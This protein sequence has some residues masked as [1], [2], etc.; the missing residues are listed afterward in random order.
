MENKM[1]EALENQKAVPFCLLALVTLL[2]LG[3]LS[4]CCQEPV[5]SDIGT[6]SIHAAMLL[7]CTEDGT[8]S[9]ETV[10]S[11]SEGIGAD[12]YLTGGDE[13]IATANGQSQTLTEEKLLFN[14]VRYVTEFDFDDPGAEFTISLERPNYTPAPNSHVTLPERIAIQTPQPDESFTHEESITLAWE[15]S[16]T[17]DEVNVQFA[18]SCRSGD[19]SSAGTRYFTVADSGSASYT[20]EDLL[21]GQEL[22]ANASCDVTITLARQKSGSLSPEYRGG[23]IVSRRESS[24]SVEIVP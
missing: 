2:A 9:V 12:I 8:T 21:S 14:V 23:K 6:D 17:P 15:P 22:G 16:G 3:L 1:K 5:D 4:G 10:L 13:L 20:V 11:V 7:K 19:E 24:V 18:M